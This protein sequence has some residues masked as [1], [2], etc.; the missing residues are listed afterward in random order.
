MLIFEL[1]DK[2]PSQGKELEYDLKDDLICFMHNDPM[3]YREQVFPAIYKFKKLS[4]QGKKIHPKAFGPLVKK[5]YEE[6]REKFPVQGLKE[7]LD[8]EMFEEMCAELHRMESQYIKD[9]HYDEK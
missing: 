7:S 5:A 4:E 1:F 2:T 6:Y 3:F 9:G 8:E